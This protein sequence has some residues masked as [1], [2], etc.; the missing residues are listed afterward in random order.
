M[1]VL[2]RKERL[3]AFLLFLL[4]FLITTGTLIAAI[5]VN[6]KLPLKENEVLKAENETILKE[7]NFQKGFSEKIEHVSKLVDSLD[8][9]PESFQFIEQ[10]ITYE[11]VRLKEKLP[12]DSD[13][14]LKLYDN[15]ILT[16][17]DL[18]NTKKQLLQV[19]DSKKE[20]DMLN[21]Q[22][23]AYEEDNKDLAR[24]LELA[25]QLNMRP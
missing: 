17:K 18:V 5:F 11:L 6:F 22:I 1:D 13:Q 9:A 16:V 14:S 15:Y 23:K 21:N 3:S 12:P 10:G 2:N 7:F 8:K 20:I 24:E 4:M 19:S 25:R